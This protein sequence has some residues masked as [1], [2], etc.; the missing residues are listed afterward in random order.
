MFNIFKYTINY[1][2]A[3]ALREND[4]ISAIKLKI[5]IGFSLFLFLWSLFFA[6]WH[7]YMGE[8][9]LIYGTL[10]G[11][12]FALVLFYLV[13]NNIF[14]KSWNHLFLGTTYFVL[15]YKM[16]FEGGQIASPSLSWMLIIPMFSLKIQGKNASLYWL[17]IIVITSIFFF[18][19]PAFGLSFP[20]IIDSEKWKLYQFVGFSILPLL[21]VTLLWIFH[22]LE[23]QVIK[24]FLKN[25]KELLKSKEKSERANQAKSIF[26]ATMSHEI[27][28]PL[29]AII[30]LTDLL[31]KTKIN[32]EQLNYIRTIKKSG[33]HLNI[34]INDILDFT[35]IESGKI[36]IETVAF[37]LQRLLYNSCNIIALRAYQE[38]IDFT[39][40]IPPQ[41]PTLLYGDS[42]RLK[43]ILI[44]LANNALKFTEKG[45]INIRVKPL[46]EKE[47]S[48]KLRFV[49]EDTGVGIPVANL[50]SIFK[51]F[52]QAD[53]STTRKYGGTGLGLSICKKLVNL[54]GG[55]INIKSETGSGTKIWFEL[56]LRK[57]KPAHNKNLI[58]DFNLE[59][60]KVLIIDRNKNNR[61]YLASYLK[62]WKIIPHKVSSV[63]NAIR[64][65][66]KNPD[67]FD[68]VLIDTDKSEF[69]P[70]EIGK[71]FCRLN[72]GLF[73][74]LV[75]L[76][77]NSGKLNWGSLKE[78][79]YI[80]YLSKPIMPHRLLK[81]LE[82]TFELLSEYEETWAYSQ[83]ASVQQDDNKKKNG[84][85]LIVEDNRVNQKVTASMTAKLGFDSKIATNGKE[86]LELL[87][88]ENFN[89]V[90][91]DCQMPVLDGFE[92]TK[93]IREGRYNINKN[94]PVIAITANVLKEDFEK[95]FL[96]GMNDLLP[97]PITSKSLSKILNKWIELK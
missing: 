44:N 15:L 50:K 4:K 17:V 25:R 59:N 70:G 83:S 96:S 36:E 63:V 58:S 49:V 86:A 62:F 40:N 30:G 72:P 28:T 87:E 76:T 47:N 33:E 20:N 1:L 21:A 38:N 79:G 69:S 23:Q 31:T 55:K 57:Q 26:L 92:T 73:Q 71:K 52:T 35:K 56:K 2:S 67:K 39:L 24:E 75:L 95:C 54:M 82:Y 32:S 22:Y 94:I 6:S 53:S 90:L 46:S 29:N 16:C 68:A 74:K 27:R 8:Y 12:A 66:E 34:L 84:L 81:S 61:D 80:I 43:Q 18:L 10:G 77:K 91:M 14:R 65:I 51:S 9:Q 88:K 7:Y 45:S 89:L 97:K 5:M 93:L 3:K 19:A 60:Q 42:H 48:I 41:T 13:K 85:I 37:D 78:A 11:A 64:I